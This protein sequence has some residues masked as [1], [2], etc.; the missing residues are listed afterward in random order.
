MIVADLGGLWDAIQGAV[1]WV[2]GGVTDTVS[3]LVH[4]VAAIL[5][6][7]EQMPTLVLVGTIWTVN[8]LVA[9]IG[10]SV[11][12]LLQQLPTMPAFPTATGGWV[13]WLQWL[14]PIGSLVGV[15]TMLLSLFLAVL[16]IRVGLNWM[17]A[18]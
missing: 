5:C 7:I 18:L 2:T 8:A 12:F 6:F 17:K 9:G 13:A 15:L 11:D 16:V 4:V 3:G 1:S 14:Y 10:S